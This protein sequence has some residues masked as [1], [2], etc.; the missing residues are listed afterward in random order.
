M[1]L[2]NHVLIVSALEGDVQFYISD[3]IVSGSECNLE[4]QVINTASATR[5]LL[6]T[7]LKHF[8]IF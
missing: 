7:Y 8:E 4:G 3:L 5:C 2:Y 1:Q 6:T